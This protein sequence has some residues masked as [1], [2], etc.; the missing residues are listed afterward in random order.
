MN[1]KQILNSELSVKYANDVKKIS[2]PLNLL[3]LY[4]PTKNDT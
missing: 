4:F 2:L 3:F 1:R